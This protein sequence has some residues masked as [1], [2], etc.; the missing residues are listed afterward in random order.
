MPP[1]GPTSRATLVRTLRTLGFQG[2]FSGGKHQFMSKNNLRVR[3]P[4]PHETD[5]GP[6]L[7]RM[8]LKE[9]GVSV[10]EWESV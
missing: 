5:I 1:W 2:P 8:I 10:R 4:N 9:A 7:L 3:I 6:N